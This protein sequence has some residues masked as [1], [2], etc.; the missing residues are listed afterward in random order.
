MDEYQ[1]SIAD[2]QKSY[3]WALAS[4]AT[5]EG[6]ANLLNQDLKDELGPAEYAK[7]YG[8]SALAT[9]YEQVSNPGPKHLLGCVPGYGCVSDCQ[10][11]Q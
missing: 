6:V 10:V 4:R 11:H 8:D 3:E 9:L 5:W 7:R 1:A 2:L